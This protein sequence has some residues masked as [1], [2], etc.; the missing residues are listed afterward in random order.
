M[1][2]VCLH[3]GDGRNCLMISGDL[4]AS[5]SNASGQCFSGV[6]ISQAPESCI[7]FFAEPGILQ[8]SEPRV[9]NSNCNEGQ[10]KTYEVTRGSHY[11]ADARTA[12]PET[13]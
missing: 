8:S 6:S 10:M 1:F 4:S 9:S 3:I 13:Y 5:A 7:C 11:D 12:V 2:E